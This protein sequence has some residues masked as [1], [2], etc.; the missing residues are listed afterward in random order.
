[1]LRGRAHDN[2]QLIAILVSFE[3]LFSVGHFPTTWKESYLELMLLEDSQ[4]VR[5]GHTEW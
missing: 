1:M 4:H 5:A 3:R 2:Q